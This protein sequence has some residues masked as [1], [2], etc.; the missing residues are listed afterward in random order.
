MKIS[1]PLI[2]LILSCLSLIG[3]ISII[4]LSCTKEKK[5]EP[6][7]SLLSSKQTKIEFENKL[8]FDNEFN[9]YTY[10]NFYNGGGVAL[11]DVNNDGLIDIY[12]TANQLPN[13]LYLNK[14]NFEFEDITEKAGVAGRRAW[15]TGVTMVDMNSDGYLDIYVCNSG[16]V[17]GDNKQNE[18]FI[19]QGDGTFVEEAEKYGLADR[20]F[21]THIS[22]FDYDKDGDLDAYLLNN[23][24]RAIGSFDLRENERLERDTLGGDKLYKNEDGKFIDVS[25]EAGIYGSVIGFGL[26][27]TVG[28]INQ[29]DWLDMYI[30]NDF[31]E[32]DYIYINQQDGT[33]KEVL[34]EKMTSISGASM[35]ADMADINNDGYPDIFVTEMLPKHQT[36]RKM[37]TTYENWDRYQYVVKN[38]Y[39]HQFTRNVM[40]LNNGD[41][42][43]S[44]IAR[45]QQ[46]EAT[47]WS[48]GALI[49]D[50][51]NDGYKD[52][53]VANG[54]YQ[55]LT[56][57]DYLNYIA[58]S[59]TKRMIITRK[60]V[61][62]KKLT[63]LIPSNKVPNYAFRN[64]PQEGSNIPLY[65]NM[66]SS[67]G[68]SDSTFSNG[69]A[70][71]DLDNDGD[72]DLVVNNVNMPSFVYRNNTKGNHYIKLELSAPAPNLRAFGA[73]VKLWAGDL[74]VYQEQMPIRG[75][76][77]SVDERMNIGLGKYNSIDSIHIIWQDGL[78][79]AIYKLKADT[80]ISLNYD[81]LKKASFFKPD[82]TRS[83]I[84]GISSIFKQ[85]KSP[86]NFVHKE[87]EFIDFNR[88]PLLFSMLSQE[89]PRMAIADLNGDEKADMFITG[90]KGQASSLFFQK[91]DGKFIA[92]KQEVF[93]QDKVSED[94]E[95]AIFDADNDGDMDIYV[96]SG[97]NEFPSSSSA[98]RDRLYLN[99]SKGNFTKAKTQV[100]PA[101]AYESTSTVVAEDYD[102]D[103]DKD[104]FVGIRLKPFYYGRATNG[105]ILE[106]DG[107]G[108]FSNITKDFAP[109]LLGLGMITDAI[110]QDI[111]Q[112]GKKDL[113]VVG[114]WMNIEVFINTGKSLERKT[115][116][117]G[118]DSL[119][120][121]WNTIEAKD[122]DMDGD[123]DFV[124]GNHGLNSQLR[125][126]Y[127]KPICL[128]VSD[129]D[130]NGKE[131]HI[132]CTYEGDVSY[133]VH[134]KHDLEK[135]LPM[136]KKKFVKYED[137]RY[138]TMSDIF[139]EKQLHDARIL[140]VHTLKSIIL[141]NEANTFK[142]LDL[143][144]EAQLSPVHAVVID[145]FDGDH[146][147]D[148]LLGG[149]NHDVKPQMGIY[150]ASWGLLLR[151]KGNASFQALSPS[152]SGFSVRGEIRDMK[153]MNIEGEK[154]VAVA[155]NK[156]A[157]LFLAMLHWNTHVPK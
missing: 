3:I 9:I 91:K 39:Y 20:G 1:R 52:L 138:A 24:Y 36:R 100:L 50:I 69:S 73:K 110:W 157:M 26:G 85:V 11:G 147:P 67:W 56:N 99:D 132:L 18:F 25:K 54:I 117:W 57:Q 120:G 96:A 23:S 74:Y 41:G 98:L 139:T 89:G 22:F 107:K 149:N 88:D 53:F 131:E 79:T 102:Q 95:I 43:F 153:L 61:D 60:G 83:S 155:R 136:V 2:P 113:L 109:D 126:S 127:D 134:L 58:N 30:S 115:K 94:A 27:I 21:S 140:R 8:V 6:L 144:L 118:L 10:R 137:Y 93:S 29:D 87:N 5:T 128:Y 86:L 123:I 66:A 48:W 33:F 142:A 150:D 124:V 92:S 112:D 75:F 104:L 17:K 42:T 101:G 14:G 106:N 32:R 156:E 55:D 45:L 135:Q 122:L 63:D 148:I 111:N 143:P 80:S 47:D 82:A 116:A 151:N 81:D 152:K 133:P 68:L 105:Y 64:I 146:L 59:E 12:F 125:T 78:Q 4:N 31:F 71:G 76:Q 145:D 13:R 19:N 35:G 37:V 15:S 72:L 97:G 38:G 51:D 34:T 65:K 103:G 49:F 7:F 44:E 40:Q 129:F 114:E 154:Y 84:S 141:L 62:F 130:K 70:Y 119:R 46:I 77:S 121:W 16:D 108:N 28:D 90:A